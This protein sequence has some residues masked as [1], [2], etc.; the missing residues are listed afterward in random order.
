MILKQSNFTKEIEER[1]HNVTEDRDRFLFKNNTL[2]S[3]LN[4]AL[5]RGEDAD[6][7]REKLKALQELFDN[8]CA[9]R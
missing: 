8:L 1:L 6:E 4:V 7:L 2:E 5:L 3:E 9:E